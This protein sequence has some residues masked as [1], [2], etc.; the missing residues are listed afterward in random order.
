MKHR[1][2]ALIAAAT[3]TATATALADDDYHYRR[4]HDRVEY[5]RVVGVTP[6][7]RLVEVVEPRESCW[8]EQVRHR[9]ASRGDNTAGLVLGGIIGGVVGNRFGGGDGRRVATV[10]G[11]ILGAGL[12]NE[13]AGR[14]RDGRAYVTS[15]RRCRTVDEVYTEE[16]TVGY[17]VRY[18]YH[19]EEFITRM[20]HPPGE[21]IRVRVRVTPED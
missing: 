13:L 11:T 15:E 8:T 7:T 16:R 2:R 19:G 9:E 6:V 14:D 3:L 1:Y 18:R 4:H 20:D 21:R 12:G 5:A 17:R 10:A